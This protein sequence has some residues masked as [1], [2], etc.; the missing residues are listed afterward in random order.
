MNLHPVLSSFPLALLCLTI[1]F[2]VL[3][4]SHYRGS[5]EITAKIAITLAAISIGAAFYS[6]YGAA[7]N[8]DQTFRISDDVI[9]SHH[10]MGRLLLFSV[11][12]CALLRYFT[13]S[14][15]YGRR[16]FDAIYLILLAA[17]FG[18]VI[19]TGFLGGELVFRHGAGVFAKP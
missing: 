18:L 15:T 4:R 13:A 9:S 12:P 6:G 16:V 14:A 3:N 5:L 19:A 17:T 2:E 7:E 10:S 11:I 1:I 8:A